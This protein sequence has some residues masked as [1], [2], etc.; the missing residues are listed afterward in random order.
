[1]IVLRLALAIV[2]AALAI[3]FALTLAGGS[4]LV[5]ALGQGL[6]ASRATF[7]LVAAI[8]LSAA[9]IAVLVPALRASTTP[10]SRSLRDE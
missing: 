6:S 4:Q 7:H 8:M 5:E 10:P 9:F 3:A 1:M 2:A